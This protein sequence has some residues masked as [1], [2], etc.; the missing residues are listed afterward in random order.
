MKEFSIKSLEELLIVVRD[1]TEQY[2]SRIWYRG[3]ANNLW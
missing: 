1:L 3:Q 2:G